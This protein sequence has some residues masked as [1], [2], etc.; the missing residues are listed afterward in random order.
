VISLPFAADLD[1]VA[2][3]SRLRDERPVCEVAVPS[4]NV[5]LLVGRYN[6]VKQVYTDSRFS[7][8]P[9]APGSPRVLPEGD[10][11][12][13]A[14]SMV[15]ME[16]ARPVARRRPVS[17]HLTVR[18]IDSLRQPTA[19]LAEDLL[20]QL[21]AAGPPAEMVEGFAT[22]MPGLSA[23]L[24]A[25]VPESDYDFFRW[26]T[27][28]LATPDQYTRA[29][30]E[31][32]TREVYEYVVKL[33]AAKHAEPGEDAV[34][35]LVQAA[36]AGEFPAEALPV[37]IMELMFA[38]M[39]NTKSVFCSGLLMLLRRPDWFQAISVDDHFGRQFVA[40]TL[41][42]HTHPLLGLPRVAVED[43]ELTG[44]VVK[45]GQAV[46]PCLVAANRDPAIFGQPDAFD[47]AR[48]CDNTLSFG[49]GPH[50][51]L[52]AALAR[53][54]LHVAFTTVAR[55]MPMLR[56]AVSADEVRWRLTLLNYNLIKLQVEW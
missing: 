47:P 28:P 41:R 12:D 34:S 8:D 4:G 13:N 10:W 48:N 56:L 49:Y 17:R 39:V 45:R 31:Q 37:V 40:E 44:G 3:Y 51:C 20:D 42:Y 2:E 46:L 26:K 22:P 24:L 43:V 14:L 55:R 11:S 30:F 36:D 50:Y 6:D 23:A 32:A 52:G 18:K 53:M 7:R 19:A 5:M 54:Q 33:A 35:A 38:G 27:W 21:I 25:G 16:G 15:N 29:E 9:S 1:P